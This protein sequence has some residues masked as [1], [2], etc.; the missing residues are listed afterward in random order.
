MTADDMT[1]LAPS[2]RHPEDSIAEALRDQIRSGSYKAG[3]WLPTERKLAENLHVDRR[4]IRLAINRLVSSG[5]VIRQPHC[6]PIIAALPEEA[7]VAAPAQALPAASFVALLMWHGGQIERTLTSQQRIFWGM[8]QALAKVGR[9]AV[10]MDLGDSIGT[11]AGNAAREAEQMRY[12]LQHGFG[13]AVF[14]PYA[15]QS[16]RAL[17][18]EV[19][20]AIPLVAIDR[21][22]G[23]ETDFVGVD[24][25]GAMYGAV[26]HLIDQGHRRIAYITKSE[27]IA[28]V[29]ER[30]RGYLDAMRDA[31]LND[32][33]LPISI[34]ESEQKWA[35][36]ETVFRLPAGERPTAAAVF[37]D[38]SAFHL[39]E[40]LGLLGLSVP[41]DVALTGFDDIV[42]ALPNGTGLTTAAQPYEEIGRKAAEL[43][44]RRMK[45]P[46]AP[47]RS[48]ELPAPLI[49]RESSRGRP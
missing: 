34:R 48:V 3:D 8:N 9:H 47:M 46:S 41:G 4:V 25:Y 18:E 36:I 32:T 12:A 49:V 26:R 2:A 45:D 14:Y 10:F 39:A 17:I 23:A 38:Y 6:R 22:G 19:R 31:D 5:L 11:E 20:Q 29:Q 21:R 15:Y 40:R 44:L 43:I 33:V 30:T 16:N 13:G 27:Q 42:P 1:V 35:V 28:A 24:N 7:P 37:N